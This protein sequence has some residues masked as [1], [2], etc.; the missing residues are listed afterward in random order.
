MRRP[1]RNVLFE[2]KQFARCQLFDEVATA[3]QIIEC[4]FVAK[5]ASVQ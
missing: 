2:V 3:V 4:Q 1:C 5:N